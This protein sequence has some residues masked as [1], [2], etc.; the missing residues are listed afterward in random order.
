M[1][2]I[3]MLSK[4][5]NHVGDGRYVKEKKKKNKSALFINFEFFR[6]TYVCLAYLFIYFLI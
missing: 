1:G 3:K 5:S 4:I 2:F 6:K